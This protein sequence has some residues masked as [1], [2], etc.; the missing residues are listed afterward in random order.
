MNNT[1][2]QQENP[3]EGTTM[4]VL[5]TRRDTEYKNSAEDGVRLGKSSRMSIVTEKGTGHAA[6][7]HMD[8][9][10]YKRVGN[11]GRKKRA[12]KAGVQGRSS[13]FSFPGEELE[14]LPSQSHGRTLPQAFLCFN[15]SWG[16]SLFRR[17]PLQCEAKS[18]PNRIRISPFSHWALQ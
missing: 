16:E 3:V 4:E 1:S 10:G 18:S 11:W 6:S 17:S 15:Y 12:V 2:Q 9:T 5:N 7:S 8:K 14:S 13:G